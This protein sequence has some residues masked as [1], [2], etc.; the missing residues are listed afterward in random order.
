MCAEWEMTEGK[1]AEWEMTDS[2]SKLYLGRW[3]ERGLG[4]DRVGNS[5]M[6][7]QIGAKWRSS[8]EKQDPGQWRNH[9]PF[10]IAYRLCPR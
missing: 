3:T 1:E 7:L 10:R 4:E 8:E 2:S 6:T 5:W 9:F